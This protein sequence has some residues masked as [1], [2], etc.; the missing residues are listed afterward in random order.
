MGGADRRVATSGVR[1]I[2]MADF[3]E[4]AV[5][6]DGALRCWGDNTR[7]LDVSSVEGATAVTVAD[8]RVVVTTTAGP[9]CFGNVFGPSGGGGAQG[10]PAPRWEQLAC[11]DPRMPAAR[12]CAVGADAAIQCTNA[13]HSYGAMRPPAGRFRAASLGRLHG[14]AIRDDRALDCWGSYA[15]GVKL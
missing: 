6:H 15:G 11:D 3:V 13:G 12:G 2:A 4:C 5:Y 7:E 8:D 9:V 14:C 1:A 10:A